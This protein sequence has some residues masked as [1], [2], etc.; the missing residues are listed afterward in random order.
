MAARRWTSA[1]ALL[2]SSRTSLGKINGAKN[3]GV[4]ATIVSDA[5]GERLLLRSKTT[6]EASGFRM[7]ATDVDG[8]N[9]DDAGLSRLVA[10]A[11]TD[12]AADARATVNGIAVTSGS[13]TFSNTVS[14]VTFNALKVT[15]DPVD[16]TVASDT[17][18]VK[19]NIE[20]FVKAY[21]A[22]NQALNQITDYDKDTKTAGLLQ[23]DSSTVIIAGTC[24]WRCSR[25]Q[26]K[27]RTLV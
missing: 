20:A 18:G 22:A 13:N 4:T 25:S 21:N 5:S 3:L 2:T 19:Q 10:G 24:A 26:L 15:T 11:A 12:Y 8:D 27:L 1:S 16:I 9:T 6:G 23:G 17:S 14:G 7:T